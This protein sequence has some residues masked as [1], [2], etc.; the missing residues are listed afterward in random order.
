MAANTNITFYTWVDKL[1]R[2]TLIINISDLEWLTSSDV[3]RNIP[4]LCLLIEADGPV[5]LVYHAYQSYSLSGS[6]KSVV[7]WVDLTK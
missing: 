2:M 3:Y 4:L 1:S 7:D 5:P 6:Y